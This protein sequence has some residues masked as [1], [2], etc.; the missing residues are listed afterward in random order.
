MQNK[1][2]GIYFRPAIQTQFR[3]HIT[4][5]RPL[6]SKHVSHLENITWLL[7]SFLSWNISILSLNIVFEFKQE[8]S[9][10]LPKLK[11]Y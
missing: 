1:W 11:S 10:F 5:C 6:I 2:N 9:L 4:K 3:K 8:I 7:I